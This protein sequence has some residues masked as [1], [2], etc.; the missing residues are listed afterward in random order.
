LR[1][2]DDFEKKEDAVRIH[3]ELYEV[4][5]GEDLARMDRLEGHPNWYRREELDIEIDG[6]I[7][8][9]EAY[10]Y[11]GQAKEPVVKSGSFRTH[12]INKK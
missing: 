7:R 11:L 3:G 12:R 4:K 5:P 9:A 2:I 10:F 8:N 1:R 6:Q